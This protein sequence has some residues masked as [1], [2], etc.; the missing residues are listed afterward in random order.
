MGV[1]VGARVAGARPEAAGVGRRVAQPR[2]ARIRSGPRRS[3]WLATAL[4]VTSLASSPGCASPP[5]VSEAGGFRHLRHGYR[6]GAPPESSP[7][8]ERVEV[9]HAALAYR[10]PG[11]VWMTLSSRCKIPLTRPDVLARHLR[12]DIPP[13]TL[14]EAGPVESHGLAG[15]QQVFDASD[16]GAVVRMKTVT[17][18]IG[19][20]A[21]DAV[22]S[23]RD[24]AGFE[25]ALS[26]FDAWW[27]TLTPLREPAPAVVAP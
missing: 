25:S 19:R 26:D 1:W 15:W 7:P 17:L 9:K 21:L 18:L 11:P 13:H 20:C 27:R 22:L 2:P 3:R 14:R 6:I 4:C 10:R 8:W 5:L 23:A 24:G 12:I 16:G